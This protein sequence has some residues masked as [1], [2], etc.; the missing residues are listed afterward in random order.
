MTGPCLDSARLSVGFNCR[1]RRISS[2]RYRSK[3]DRG[4]APD[5]VVPT[6]LFLPLAGCGNL[7]EQ[8]HKKYLAGQKPD[9]LGMGIWY[10]PYGHRHCLHHPFNVRTCV[11][12]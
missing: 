5:R 2:R 10:C 8:D 12:V 4:D 9:L 1:S 3:L 11:A 7:T 6:L